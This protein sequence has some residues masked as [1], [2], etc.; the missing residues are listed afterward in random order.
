MTIVDDLAIS[1]ELSQAKERIRE[2]ESEVQRLTSLINIE[3]KPI[4]KTHEQLICEQELKK[5]LDLSNS[6]NPVG[7]TLE[8]TKR[9]DLYVK[10]L[11]LVKES[12]KEIKP[13]YKNVPVGVTEF[14]LIELASIPEAK[15]EA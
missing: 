7:L 4:E 1:F 6:R 2:L 8:E 14:Q 11:Y 12:Q 13:D 9:F 5:L 15:E 3:V 10:N